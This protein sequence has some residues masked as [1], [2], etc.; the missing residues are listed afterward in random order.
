MP[1]Y[2]Y[3]KDY[4]FAAFVTNLGKYNEGEL[5]GE[6]VKFPTTAEEMKQVFD[7]IGIGQTDDFGHT[8]EEWFITDYDC[9]VD[10][11]YDKLG[12]YE[13]LDELNYLASKLDEM[14]RGEFE[15]FQ[16]AMEIG[17]HSGSVQEII[18]LTENLDC[19]DVY[20]GIEDYDDLGRYYIDELD[21]MQVPEHLKNYID[22]EAYGRDIALDESGDFTSFGYVRDTGSSFHEYY[23]G[24]RGSIPE[25]YRVMTFQDDIPEEELSEWAMDI[26]F[27]MEEYFRQND[28]QYAAEHPEEHAAREEIYESLMA[29]QVMALEEKL[30]ALGQTQD[31]YL[32]SEVEKFKEASR[33]E[34]ALDTSRAEVRKE[35]A[36]EDSF[37]IYQLKGGDETLDYRF[38]PLDAIQR[39]G[40]SVDPANYELVYTA[41]LTERDNLESIYTRFNID[42]P[43]DFHGHS[44]SVSDIV[45]LH[46]DGKDTAHYCDRFGFSQVPE[47]LEPERAKEVTIPTPDQM[48]TGETVR[49]PR[50]S[51]YVTAMS[52]EQMEAA[53]YGL[54]H[55]SDDG[56][57]LIMGNG[58]RAFA[59]L[60]EQPEKDNPLRTAEMTLE[61]DYGMIDGVINNGKRG[62][63]VEKAKETAE[64]GGTEKK[65]SIRERLEDAKKECSERKPPEKGRPGREA[66]EHGGL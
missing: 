41:P 31:D 55:Q 57:Y 7:R 11:L 54:H 34:A 5:V 30:A 61:D 22:Y 25:E 14:D 21:A 26:A 10:G 20:P 47:F 16:V 33:Y 50:G 1:V 27:D 56:K 63:E 32:P 24:D 64:R 12:E 46:Q 60:A 3:D 15:Q 51:F 36:Q 45:V 49:T 62:E 65:T 29:G 48:E 37:S 52:R 42:R 43:A 35:P 38:E 23:D 13:S 8:Y 66:P 40:L 2:G 17:D 6:W 39:N 44:L 59:V 18:N 4:P 9:Y 53:G 19:Y 58:T 28:P